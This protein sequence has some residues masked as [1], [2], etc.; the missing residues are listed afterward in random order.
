MAGKDQLVLIRERQEAGRLVPIDLG[1]GIGRFAGLIGNQRFLDGRRP[2]RQRGPIVDDH[3]IDP[4]AMVGGIAIV[5]IG[6]HQLELLDAG[7]RH[8]DLL[9]CHAT[10]HQPGTKQLLAIAADNEFNTPR[11]VGTPRRILNPHQR[12]E[13]R[14]LA[15][16]RQLP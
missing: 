8:L 2:D 13:L 9:G 12:L 3:G 6:S 4:V 1:S 11:L 14:C 5:A 16:Q 15:R 10:A 7:Q